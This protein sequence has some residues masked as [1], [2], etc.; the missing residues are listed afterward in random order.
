MRIKFHRVERKEEVVFRA[1]HQIKAEEVFLINENEEAV[2]KM[3]LSKAL[4]LAQE[5]DLDLVEVNLKPIRQ[6]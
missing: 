5:A 3:S 6:W 4:G 2:G 1:N